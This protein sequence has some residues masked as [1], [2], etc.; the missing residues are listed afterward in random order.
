MVRE[1]YFNHQSSFIFLILSQERVK[2]ILY[3]TVILGGVVVVVFHEN[4][5]WNPAH[6]FSLSSMELF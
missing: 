2:G 1:T 6:V 3:L 4:L 5:A